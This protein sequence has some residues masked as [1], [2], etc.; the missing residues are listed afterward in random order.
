[1]LET[2]SLNFTDVSCCSFP[3]PLSSPPCPV[4]AGHLLGENERCC[5]QKMSALGNLH[6]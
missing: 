5:L 4:Q 3:F 1:M 2:A 6:I